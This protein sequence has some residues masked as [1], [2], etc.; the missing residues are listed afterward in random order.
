MFALLKVNKKTNKM[1][2]EEI[3]NELD[4]G[5]YIKIGRLVAA[6]GKKTTRQYVYLILTEKRNANRGTGKLIKEAAEAIAIENIKQKQL[7]NK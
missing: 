6:K 1:T 2:C 7:A 4:I 5:D 3:K